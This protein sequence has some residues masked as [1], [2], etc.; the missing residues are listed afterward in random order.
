MNKI[1]KKF[2]FNLIFVI[3]IM[4]IILIFVNTKFIR[5]FYIYEK[6][7]E[8]TKIFNEVLKDI[9]DENINRIENA[10]NVIIA[11]VK[12][13][14]DIDILNKII[15]D[16]FLE[17]GIDI[18]NYW[19][20]DEEYSAVIKKGSNV[21]IYSQN[22]FNYSLLTEYINVDDN[23][24]IIA[25]IIPNINEIIQIV[26][27]ISIII[28]FLVV[29]IVF[30]VILSLVKNITE[31]LNKICAATQNIAMQKFDYLDIKTNDE[32]EI[33]ANNINFMSSEIQ[34]YQESII[35]KNKDI[36]N[37]L[38]SITHD[39]KT[40]ISLIKL[41]ANGIKDGLDNGTFLDTIIKQNNKLDKI[42]EGLLSIFKIK[43]TEVLKEN[44]E[45][46]HLI[47]EIIE[48]QKINLKLHNINL[49][50]NIEDE[51]FIYANKEEIIMLLENLIT[52]AIKYTAD[53]YIRITFN[54][55]ANFVVSNGIKSDINF[56]KVFE[57]FYV[58]ENS[59][60]KELSGTGLGLSIVKTICE[61][62]NYPYGY[63]KT[64]DKINFYINFI[65]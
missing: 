4:L 62:N 41:Y 9:S 14:D 19:F 17:K 48:E 29:A 5:G 34:K 15:K 39:L 51:V 21:K 63:Y 6:E 3:C 26:N 12:N 10:K 37:L 36:E 57:E 38:N 64:N 13:C 31:P 54:S 58:G 53:N 16:E 20:W 60:K 61:K 49:D 42:I 1:S 45:V 25:M 40:P 33:L 56:E 32:I 7:Q 22:D 8:I 23:F 35:N 28:F 47:N 11:K 30:L 44:F 50:C 59:S 18:E 24:L 27:I 65:K 2:L 52:N 55:D 43:Q 46:S